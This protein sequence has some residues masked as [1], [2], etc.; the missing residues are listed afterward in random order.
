MRLCKLYFLGEATAQRS[1]TNT[2]P[3][4]P[5][6]GEEPSEDSEEKVQEAAIEIV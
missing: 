5:R 2:P 4:S 3:N 1:S 6:L